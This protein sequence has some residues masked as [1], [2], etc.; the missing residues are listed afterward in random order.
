MIS[1]QINSDFKNIT[2]YVSYN[3]NHLSAFI[4]SNYQYVDNSTEITFK[5]YK[6]G[7]FLQIIFKDD[8]N[9]VMKVFTTV[10]QINSEVEDN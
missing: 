6:D 3:F 9:H 4:S 10:S 8:K 2:D 7:K 1:I 5:S